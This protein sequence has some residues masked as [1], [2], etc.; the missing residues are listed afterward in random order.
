MLFFKKKKKDVVIPE[1]EEI[2]FTFPLYV[3]FVK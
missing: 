1:T 2:T 3:V